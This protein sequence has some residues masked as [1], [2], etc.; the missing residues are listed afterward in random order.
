MNQY[1]PKILDMTWREKTA[2]ELG[3]GMAK[4]GLFSKIFATDVIR[5]LGL[6]LLLMSLHFEK[7]AVVVQM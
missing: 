6:L 4:S 5:Q 2:V 3:A 1:L 7:G